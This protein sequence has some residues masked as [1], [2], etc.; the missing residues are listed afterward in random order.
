MRHYV[1]DKKIYAIMTIF[2]TKNVD[3]VSSHV[4]TFSSTELFYNE[5]LSFHILHC[6]IHSTSSEENWLLFVNCF[7]VQM[8][9]YGKELTF[10]KVTE[11]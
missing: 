10:Q 4:V 3:Q 8:L 5:L 7:S 9:W 2:D 11:F 1:T 6:R